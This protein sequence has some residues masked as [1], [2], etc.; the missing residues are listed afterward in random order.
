MALR[1]ARVTF[2]D[3]SP[4]LIERCQHA[5]TA[6]F[7]ELYQ[8][9]KSQLYGFLFSVLRDYDDT[10]E[11][12]QECLIRLYRHIGSLKEPQ[13][14]GFWLRRMAVN[15]CTT[16]IVRKGKTES[17]QFDDALEIKNESLVFKPALLPNPRQQLVQKEL[18]AEINLA[19]SKLP[20]KQRVAVMLFEVQGHSIRDIAGLLGCTEGAVKFN[21]HQARKKLRHSLRHHVHKRIS[22]EGV[23]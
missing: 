1:C 14:F 3:I 12:F 13:K 4:E 23:R 8:A 18:M 5:D 21:L 7:D 20:P 2:Q 16:H 15:Q 11:V 19:I 9:I 22:D 17:Y 10:D 6:A